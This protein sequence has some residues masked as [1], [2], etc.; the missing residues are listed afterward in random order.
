MQDRRSEQAGGLSGWVAKRAGE[1]E[2]T[3][4]DEPTMHRQKFLW[5]ALADYW[6]RME[7]DGWENVPEPP[8]LLV[9]IH[10]GA[11]SSGMLGPLVCN[12]GDGSVQTARCT[13]LPM[14]C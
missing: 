1:W 4:Q 2:L 8:V 10:S 9:G 12:G 11:R 14:T 6:F 7:I 13:A 5:N 3:G